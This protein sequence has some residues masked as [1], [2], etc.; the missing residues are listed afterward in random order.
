[1]SSPLERYAYQFKRAHKFILNHSIEIRVFQGA[2]EMGHQWIPFRQACEILDI[3]SNSIKVVYLSSHDVND[4]HMS[5]EDIV[6][7]LYGGDI[8]F[9]LTHIH[10]GICNINMKKLYSLL[11]VAL[12]T[13]PGFPHEQYLRCPVFTQDKYAYL[14]LLMPKGLCNQTF[15]VDFKDSMDYD[16]IKHKLKL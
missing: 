1:M 14:S 10:Q 6:Y 13:H 3:S 15:R 7:W 8:H 12:S 16:A 9:I 5:E 2:K 4:K 11:N